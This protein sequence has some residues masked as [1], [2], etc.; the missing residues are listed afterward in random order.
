MKQKPKALKKG[1]TIGVIAPGSPA[2]KEASE[3]GIKVLTE[4]GFHVLLG[5][6]VFHKRGY[7]AGEDE[8]RVS[9]IH[10]MFYNQ[11]VNGIVCMRG[12][13]GSGRLLD[14]IDYG[15]IARNPK[16]FVGYSDITA[17]HIAFLQKA[18]LVT[19]HGP[20]VTS[21]FAEDDGNDYTKEAFYQAITCLQ[22]LGI[23]YNPSEAND[24]EI[25]ILKSGKAWGELVGGNLALI[26]S[27]MGTPFEIDTR[28]K[29]LFLE[30][31]HE[32]IYRIDRM[33]NQLR[34]AGKLQAA[35]GFI[36]GEFI[37]Y[38]PD[39]PDESLTFQQVMEDLIL[40]LGKP[41]LMGLKCGHGKYK[42]TLP[43][44]VLAKLDADNGYVSV[45]ESA[46]NLY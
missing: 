7:L 26:A 30:D 8:I 12:G 1:D 17:L 5:E 3:K 28:N 11:E 22:P 33:I 34:L 10:R 35:S 38:E 6:S 4:M 45:I 29:I 31:I 24:N 19:F 21:D 25:K 16:V 44:G 14:K 40:P 20:M 2:P 46:L 41:T 42:M 37:D 39:N 32:Q 9:D 23:L 18:D 15:L 43:L 36:I 13:D 27:T